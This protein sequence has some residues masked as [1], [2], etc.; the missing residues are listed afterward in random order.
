[1][2]TVCIILK[3]NDII[4]TKEVAV[5]SIIPLDS[6]F[7]DMATYLNKNQLGVLIQLQHHQPSTTLNLTNVTPYVLL[8][9]NDALHYKS[10]AYSIKSGTG[11]FT[12]Q[13]PYKNLLFIRMPFEIK[14]NT[15][16]SLKLHQSVMIEDKKAAL[17]QRLKIEFP[18]T[19][20]TGAGRLFTTVRRMK[21]EKEL[22]IPI[23]WRTAAAISVATGKPG[24]EMNELEWDTFY[25][26]LCENLKREY[27]S[28]YEK[29]FPLK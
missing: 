21:A 29:L 2:K 7:I 18:L 10:A 27:P 6:S 20:H 28:L 15:V 12:V 19:M 24:N 16:L 3:E 5:N 4:S 22:E 25:S 13:T 17:L 14:I 23:A 11:S 26:D 8:C 1:M 9:F